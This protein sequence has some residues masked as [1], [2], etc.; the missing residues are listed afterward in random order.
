MQPDLLKRKETHFVL[1]R[2]AFTNPV[3]SLVIGIAVPGNPPTLNDLRTIELVQHPHFPEL[4]E[5]DSSSIGL[6]NGQVYH[7]W[8]RVKDSFPAQH[9]N[10]VID[11]T[12]PFAT[13]VDR[14]FLSAALPAP[15][16]K[17]DRDP[18]AVIKY[19]DKRLWICDAGGETGD[20]QQDPIMHTLPPNHKTV[21]YELPARWSSKLSD[22]SVEVAVGTF[23]DVR[24]LVDAATT[25]A[26]FEG[27]EVLRAGNVYLQSLGINALE[28]LPPAD[29]FVSREWGYATSNYLAADYDLGFPES[30]A[31]PTATSDLVALIKSCHKAGI[32]FIPDVVMAFATHAPMENL[33]YP[34]FHVKRGSGDPEEGHRE[35]FGGKLM[36]Y[37]Y[38]VNGYDPLT[39]SEQD[40]VPARQWMKTFLSHWMLYYRVDGIRMDSVVNFNNWDFI[41]EFRDMA[42]AHWR[43][44]WSDQSADE[45]GVE[46]RFLVIGEELAMPMELI[47]ENRL[48]ALWNE[49][50]QSRLRSVILG[51]PGLSPGDFLKQVEEM[52]DCRKLG[53]HDGSQAINYI[54]SHDVEGFRKERLYNFLHNNGV[55]LKDKQIRLAFVCLLTAVGV[56]MILAGEE[57]A[58]EH[59]L[60]VVHPHKQVDPVNFHRKEEP[61]RSEIFNYVSRL[62]HFRTSSAALALNDTRILHHD[63]TD[64]RRVVVWQRGV[65][66][67]R[68]CV[69]VVA[70]FSA[71]G[72]EN[73]ESLFAEYVIPNW[74]ALPHD[75]Q[76]MEIT[77]NRLVSIEWA[78]R[79][80]LYPWEAKVYA[81]VAV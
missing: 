42:R 79:E 30:N 57:F 59:D 27:M 41:K 43:E 75:R 7:Y 64:G 47:Y 51:G 40:I 49:K 36:K 68:E 45:A 60:L 29:S 55:A 56:P 74:P 67:S 11:I 5:L 58:D 76:W 39:A 46:E 52:V 44:R 20:W 70:N 31:S 80:P 32:R 78:G 73:P 2:P 1:W 48:D 21:I 35:D 50:F 13:T 66:G 19:A 14:R 81:M 8:F 65:T 28:L 33:N 71:W 9:R 34:D 4:W 37:N 62:V 16:D 63:V 3:P 17:V 18:A 38:R 23:Q 72:T 61:W 10:S 22:D 15:Y 69:I 77:Q 26:N 12:D 54:T 6:V 53:F 24:A 25:G